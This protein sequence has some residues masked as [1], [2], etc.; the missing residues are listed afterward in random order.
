VKPSRGES[1]PPVPTAAE[2]VDLRLALG[3]LAAWVALV[4][5]MSRGLRFT[6]FLALFSL[7]TAILA[8][9]G[10]R[11][12]PGLSSVGFGLACVAMAAAPLAVRLQLAQHGPLAGLIRRGPQLVIDAVVTGD[13]RRLAGRG[14]A[15]SARSVVPARLVAVRLS[16]RKQSVSGSVLIFGAPA[17]WAAILPGQPVRVAAR[18]TPPLRGNLLTATIFARAPPELVGRPPWWQRLA[19]HVRSRLRTASARLPGQ[20]R[21]LVP[22]LVDGDASGLDP[23]LAERFRV[24]GLSHLLVVSGAN[25][26]I[27][28]GVVGLLLRRVRASPGLTAAVGGLVLIAFVL[29]ARPSPS[30]LRAAVMGG[31]GLAATA[32]GRQRSALPLLAGTVLLLLVWSPSLA[33]DMGFELSVAASASL[34]LLAPGWSAALHRVGRLPTGVAEAVGVA[35]AAHVSTAP[36]IAALSGR[37]SVV[38]IPANLLAEPAVAP[39]TV[40]GVLAAVVASVSLPAGA[41]LAWAAGWPCRWLIWVG[42][43]FGAL[44]GASLAW[45]SGA[46]GGAALAACTA[47]ALWAARYRLPRA[48]LGVGLVAALTIQVPVRAA[49]RAWPPAGWLMTACD[50]GQGDALAVS[51]GPRS[52]IVID[53]G[54]EPLAADRCLRELGITDI[55]LLVFTH[56]HLDHVGGVLGVLHRR[57]VG[58]VAVSPLA[59]PS[60]GVRLLDDALKTR[61]LHPEVLPMGRVVRLGA[62]TVTVLAPGRVLRGTRS[63]PNNSSVVLLVSVGGHR[64]LLAGDVQVE[65]QDELLR[66]SVDLHAEVLK[67]PH[68]GSAFTDPAFLRAVHA[69]LAVISVGRNNDYGH[70]SPVTVAELAR[71]GMTIGR[72]DLDGDVCVAPVRGGS[73]RLEARSASTRG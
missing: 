71:L 59:E 18:L 54:P 8:T 4:I 66:E 38:A 23:V 15:G 61:G 28:V 68:H 49:L 14:A 29:V 39:A 40:F 50:V 19:G 51:T 6:A 9:I 11:H 65:E 37:V 26:S 7:A 31:I 42:E 55:P 10:G 44:G 34:M 32:R 57:R 72:T 3:T 63:D 52:A 5:C 22:G 16:G 30:V 1:G 24:A 25:C 62:A 73:L 64:L 36:L 21:G 69:G 45:P 43:T 33:V 56:D 20:V 53:S 17:A 47:A 41:Y 13:A 35:A 60:S 12:R 46:T 58:R 2:P 67:V 27:V 48:L 70:P